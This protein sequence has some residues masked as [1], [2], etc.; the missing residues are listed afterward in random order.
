MQVDVIFSHH[1]EPKWVRQVTNQLYDERS[2]NIFT[3]PRIKALPKIRSLR[4]DSRSCIPFGFQLIP[5]LQFAHSV[6]NSLRKRSV[7]HVGN[8]S[9]AS[10]ADGIRYP[11]DTSL[12]STVIKRTINN[13]TCSSSHKASL[14]PG[15]ALRLESSYS[16]NCFRPASFHRDLQCLKVP[17][18][19]RGC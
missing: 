15:R 3:S 18:H 6:Q 7:H 4:L 5:K 2:T 8:R 17:P 10:D 16:R 9:S 12:A 14:T 1:L 13:N 19:V 11:I